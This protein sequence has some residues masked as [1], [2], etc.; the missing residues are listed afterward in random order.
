MLKNNLLFDSVKPTP[1]HGGGVQGVHN[2]VLPRA[3]RK[4]FWKLLNSLNVALTHWA[5]RSTNVLHTAETRRNAGVETE[6]KTS[7]TD[8]TNLCVKLPSSKSFNAAQLSK[9]YDFISPLTVG[10]CCVWLNGSWSE[11]CRLTFVSFPLWLTGQIFCWPTASTE[12][13]S[14]EL[15]C[16][17]GNHQFRLLI[18]RDHVT[19]QNQPAGCILSGTSGSR[20]VQY[21][22]TTGLL[23]NR[24]INFICFT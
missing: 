13:G 3:Q 14:M 15:S 20:N 23:H 5:D 9:P 6:Q 7:R 24:K 18:P 11:L 16:L 17:R 12:R 22:S 19:W 10:S 1:T 4:S 8:R 21:C 2:P